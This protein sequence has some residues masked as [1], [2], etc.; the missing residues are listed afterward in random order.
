MVNTKCEECGRFC[1]P[2]DSGTYYG[3]ATDLDPPDPSFF[4]KKCVDKRLK[5]PDT[6]II[7]CWWHKP[8]FVSIAKSIRR[9]KK[10]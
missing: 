9:H 1:K 3:N 2:I 8:N 10:Q 5:S 4:C 6:V 7:G